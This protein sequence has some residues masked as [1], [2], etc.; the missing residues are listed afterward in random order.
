MFDAPG[1]DEKMVQLFKDDRRIRQ[2]GL[3][4]S[5]DFIGSP[6]YDSREHVIVEK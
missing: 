1:V 4:Y 5:Y 2:R 3:W 6:F